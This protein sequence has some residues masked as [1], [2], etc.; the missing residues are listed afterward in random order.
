[1][2]VTATFPQ[3]VLDAADEFMLDATRVM[4]D[5]MKVEIP[6]I[7]QYAIRVGRAN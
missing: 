6:E 2:L 7:D 5:E 3:E 4:G 1:M